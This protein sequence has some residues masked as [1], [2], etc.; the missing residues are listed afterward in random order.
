MSFTINPN[1]IDKYGLYSIALEPS[2]TYSIKV[3]PLKSRG[4]Q[5]VWRWGKEEKSRQNLNINIK[6]KIKNDGTFMIVEKYRDESV[7]IKNVWL[8]KK[9][10]T[11]QGSLQIKSIIGEGKFDYPKPLEIPEL[12]LKTTI[13]KNAIVLDFFAG[14]GTTLHAVMQLNSEDNGSR[15]CILVQGIEK[16]EKNNDLQIASKVT[17]ERNKRVINGYTKPNGDSVDGLKNNNLRYYKVGLVPREKDTR[18]IER[19]ARQS[20]NLLCIKEDVFQE[21]AMLGNLEAEGFRYFKNG[22]KQF[23]VILEPEMIEPITEELVKIDIKGKIPVYV[24]TTGLYPYTEDFWRVS[25]KVELYPYPSCIYGACEKV[26]PKLE[27]K[28]LDLPDNIELSDEEANM[29]FD[30]LNKE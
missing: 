12:I 28:L 9:F 27:D 14:S 13:S 23:I 3:M 1:E 2:N 25:D 15:Q 19:F 22:D 8:D 4:I 21:Q 18:N 6:A 7:M 16:D 20:V 26:M 30:D 10:R 5:T 24:Y 29:I 17:Y 11:E